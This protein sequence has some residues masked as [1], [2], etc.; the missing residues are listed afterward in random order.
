MAVIRAAQAAEVIRD[1]GEWAFVDLE[2]HTVAQAMHERLAVAGVG[3]HLAGRGI[4]GLAG[5]AEANRRR[6]A[7]RSWAR[8]HMRSTAR[9]A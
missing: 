4:G 3:D 5:R 7:S 2:A 9:S 6:N 1:S 8:R